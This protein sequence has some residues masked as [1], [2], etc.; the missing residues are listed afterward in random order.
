MPPLIPETCLF[1][2]KV[3]GMAHVL[4]TIENVR[5][6]GSPPAVG[7]GK[8]VVAPIPCAMLREIGGRAEN[9]FFLKYCGNL[10]GASAVD[11][12]AKDA[13]DYLGGFIVNNPLLRVIQVFLVAI[14]GV[15][16]GVLASHALGAFDCPNFL[17]GVS[18]KP[19]V[20]VLS[21]KNDAFTVPQT[22]QNCSRF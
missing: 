2:L 3:D 7:V 18:C 12:H 6:S 13:A 15:N 10:I 14:E 21:I 11:G 16:S 5:N 4:H 17:A 22:R 20:I 9:T 1:R 8:I 19:L